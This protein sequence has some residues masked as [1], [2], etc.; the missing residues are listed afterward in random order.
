MA[1]V[2][3]GLHERLAEGA[4]YARARARGRRRPSR[5]RRSGARGARVQKRPDHGRFERDAR[6]K[7]PSNSVHAAVAALRAR[8][9]V[10]SSQRTRSTA[11]AQ[12]LFR[13]EPVERLFRLKGR[14]MSKPIALLAADLDALSARAPR[15]RRDAHRGVAAGAVHA[16]RPQPGAPLPVADRRQPGCDWRPRSRATAGRGG[17]GAAR[18]RRGVRDERERSGRAESAPRSGRAGGD[19]GTPAG[20]VI[21]AGERPGTPSTVLDLTGDEPL[22]L[23]EGAARP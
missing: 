9:P 8:R 10:R 7:G 4:R 2:G 19:P 11:C 18:G 15:A 12:L 23:R 5:A 6:A 3:S 14:D 13:P 22:V 20:A 1:L 17:S 16:R 21:D